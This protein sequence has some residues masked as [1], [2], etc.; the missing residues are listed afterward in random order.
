MTV[1]TATRVTVWALIETS[2]NSTAKASPPIG[3][4]KV[5]P[6]PAAAPAAIR[7]IRWRTGIL[8]IWPTT[9]PKADPIWTIGPSRPTEPPVPIEIAE[10]SAFAITTIGRILPSR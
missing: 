9:D 7:M 3:A 4:L 6:I 1:E 8:M 2:N 10:A 5:A